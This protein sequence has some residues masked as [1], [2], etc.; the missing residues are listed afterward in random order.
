MG[1]AAYPAE[2]EP[3]DIVSEAN[4]LQA[5]TKGFTA[6]IWPVGDIDVF[7][8]TVTVVGSSLT[9]ATSDGMGGCPAGAHTY[10]RVFDSAG[11]VLAFD[12]GTNGCAS[13]SPSDN[14]S[15]IGLL[16]GKY[17]VHVESALLSILPSYT[18]AIQVT[19]PLCGDGIVQV[20]AGEQ[21]DHAG[22]NGANGDGCSATCQILGGKYLNETEPNDTQ[23]NGNSLD[24]YAG[25]VG[26]L[27]PA[28]DVDWYTIDVT[29]AGSSITAQIGD[30]FGGCPAGF[31]PEL[32]LYSPA[33][34]KLA[35]DDTSGVYPCSRIAP[36]A[37]SAAGNLPIG[38]YGLEVSHSNTGVQTSYV[39]SVQVEPPGCGDGVLEPGEQCDPGPIAVPGCSATCQLTG[40]YLPETEPNNTEA[41][42]NALGTHAGFV[43]AISPVGDL[44]YYSFTVPGPSSLVFLQTSDG[45]GGC[46]LGFQSALSLFAPGGSLIVETGSGGVGGCS[47]I[48]PATFPALA[49]GL[50]AG[51]YYARVGV[52]GNNAVC[53]LYVLGIAVRQPGCGNGVVEAGEQC[54]D[55]AANGTAG[56][57]CSVTCQS[58]PPWEIEPNGTTATAT[59]QWSGLS[60]WKGAI[61][62]VGDHDYFKLVLAT[63][64]T[65][66]LVTHDIGAPTYCTSDTVLYLDDGNGT[67]ITSNDDGGPGPGDP[68]DGGKC[69]LITQ[70]LAA[71]TYYAWVQRSG[72]SKVIPGYQL[73]LTVQ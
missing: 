72:D 3:N 49:T 66:T 48:S 21:C 2:S 59:P 44:D 42:G 25:G 39:L 52:N 20:V 7:E 55:G 14:P 8:A 27:D 67:L 33:A 22:T 46:P 51:T 60:T 19:P 26:T 30:G 62:P 43:G 65:V 56:D 24:G 38:K 6:S 47:Q 10:V 58:L 40:D 16:A 31:T 17:Y 36:Q 50:S 32:A 12:P 11:N 9:V 35:V 71:G 54:D 4:P 28:S 73:D 57:G 13:F 61:N 1:T 68:S 45:I 70:A 53:P 29:V 34:V 5:G 37:Y 63:A 15:L 69:S 23:A 41:T 18:V 64:G